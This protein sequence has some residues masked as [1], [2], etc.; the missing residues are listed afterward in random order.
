MKS[1]AC[2]EKLGLIKP[3]PTYVRFARIKE[4]THV[5]LQSVRVT[6]EHSDHES[7]TMVCLG[8]EKAVS[9]RGE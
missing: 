7:R 4:K 3:C 6:E 5:S 8:R 9:S 1:M 2:G